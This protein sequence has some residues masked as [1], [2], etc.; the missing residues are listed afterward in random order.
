MKLIYYL[1]VHFPDSLKMMKKFPLLCFPELISQIRGT[2]RA[3]G[4]EED[5][6]KEDSA[7]TET[8]GS[9]PG[10]HGTEGKAR[11]RQR[12]TSEGTTGGNN[13]HAEPSSQKYTQQELESVRR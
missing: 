12:K 1:I 9:A 10:A 5:E 6:D 3:S 8:N 4:G 7:G 13:E 11:H 2:S